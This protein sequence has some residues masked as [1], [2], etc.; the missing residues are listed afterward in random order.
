MHIVHV[1]IDVKPDYLNDF[2]TATLD[3]ARNSLREEGVLRFDVIQQI[4]DPTHIVLVEVYKTPEDNEKHRQTAHFACWRDLA[5]PM[6][7]APRTR[8]VYQNLF[9]D[10]EGW[11]ACC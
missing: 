9:P 4:D 3:N 2:I 5:E 7:A 8:A 1:H 10:D 6:M 11:Q